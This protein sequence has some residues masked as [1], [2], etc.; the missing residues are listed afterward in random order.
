MIIMI[1]RLPTEN[2]E[3][4]QLNNGELY[5]AGLVLLLSLLVTGT[6]WRIVQIRFCCE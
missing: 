2:G 4:Q 6:S 1:I 3:K 5:C